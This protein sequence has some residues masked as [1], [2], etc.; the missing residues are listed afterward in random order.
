M[1]TD[2]FG[3]KINHELKTDPYVFQRLWD[4]KK[5]FEIRFDDRDYKEND[6]LWL[7][8]TKYTG[9]EMKAGAPLEY[10]GRAMSM[11]VTDVLRG[12]IYGLMDGWVILSVE[13]ISL[14]I[15]INPY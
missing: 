5:K 14:D 11:R 10:T 6:V 12:P 15:P 13:R 8:E 9:A 2:I 4:K 7:K 3:D 1:T